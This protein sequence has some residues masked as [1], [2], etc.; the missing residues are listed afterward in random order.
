MTCPRSPDPAAWSRRSALLLAAA[1][2]LPRPAAAGTG[3]RWSVG[4]GADLP[5]MA[6][7]L[8][9]AGD[10]DTIEVWPGHYA[11]DV[12]VI[13]Q[14]RLTVRGLGTRPVFHADG[15]HAEG[16]AIWVVRG[17]DV[18]IENI[19]FRGCRVPHGNGAGIRFER[20]RL[21][22]RRCAFFDNEMG[23][24]TSNDGEAELAIEDSE[25]GQA[26]THAGAFHHLLYAGRIARLA[27]TGS[28]FSQGWIGHL[29]KSRARETRL[30]A[31][32]LVDGAGGRASY[33]VDLP[34]GGMAELIGNIVGQSTGTDNLALVS[35][36]AE[37]APWPR[38]HLRLVHN[39]LLDELPAGGRFVQAFR[40]R[41]PADAELLLL[42][43]LWLGAGSL[44]PGG[45]GVREQGNVPGALADLSDPARLDFALA[46]SSPVRRT[47]TEPVPPALRPR[48][49]FSAPLGT[50]VLAPNAAAW[51][52]G[53]VQR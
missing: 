4:R 43:N 49:E 39:T 53:A 40:E 1:A 42:N 25:F 30:L 23:L 32:L 19:E 50:R 5:S 18:L 11:G 10:D 8:R 52:P 14:R 31:N 51:L 48:L 27:V 16:K 37:G 29:V 20:G 26:P 2:L 33:E 17:E 47:A 45:V 34:N 21:R 41:L 28:R 9:R 3:R 13:E 22:L 36:G 35:F 15:R 44:A 46:A 6:E 24:L 38:S 7:A 12:G